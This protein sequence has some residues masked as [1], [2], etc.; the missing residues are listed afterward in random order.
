MRG[1]YCQAALRRERI[2]GSSPRAWGIQHPGKAARQP[3]R[4]IPTCVGNTSRLSY[5]S[6]GST[7]HPHVRGEYP[8]A[9][10]RAIRT[11]G[12][13]PRAWGIPEV[14]HLRYA[15]S[16]F[17]PTCVGNTSQRRRGYPDQ[18][19]HPHVRGEYPSQILPSGRWNGSSPRAWGIPHSVGSRGCRIRFIP[20][21][22]GNTLGLR[23]QGRKEAVHPHV[24]GEYSVLEVWKYPPAGSSP[25]AWGILRCTVR[26]IARIRFIPTCVGNTRSPL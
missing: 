4:F 17:I 2:R 15:P 18:P 3:Y 11:V 5:K 12:S 20:T 22:V 1:E 6:Y 21:C 19:V 23:L 14:D 16:R 24:R 7:V 13:S 25:R 10:L 26:T 9:A 8:Q